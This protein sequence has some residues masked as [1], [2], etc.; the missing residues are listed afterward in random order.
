VRNG[1]R[2]ARVRDDLAREEHVCRVLAP[3]LVVT[4]GGGAFIDSTDTAVNITDS[5]WT[6][7]TTDGP[8]DVW[9]ATVNDGSTADITFVV[10]A[11]CTQPTSI[12]GPTS[13]SSPARLEAAH[14]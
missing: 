10:D 1:G 13:A 3:G 2:S 5:D 12:A 14:K 6:S 9:F 4:G 11:I 8:P 7:S